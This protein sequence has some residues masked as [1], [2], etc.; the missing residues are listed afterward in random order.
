MTITTPRLRTS[1]AVAATM[2]P[3]AASM[4]LNFDDQDSPYDAIDVLTLAAFIDGRQPHARTQRLDN[5]RD[6]ATLL[7][8][9]ATA[10]RTARDS[11]G[12]KTLVRGDGWTLRAARW[13]GG[14]G[15]VTVTAV[16]DHL[17]A[18]ILAQAVDNAE[19]PDPEP[20][21]DRVD[22]GFW[23][24]TARGPYRR[25]RSIT[26]PM[27]SQLRR[28]YSMSVGRAM[29]ALVGL[30]ADHLAGQILLL[31]GPP[32]TGKT[33]ALRALAR[34][35]REWCQVDFVVDPESLF[36]EPGYLTEVI[37]GED[38]ESKW[39]LLLLEDCDELIRSDAKQA[40]GQ[41]L[42]RLLNLT[43]GLLGQGRRVLVAITTNE[44]LARLHPAITRPG[45]CLAQIEVSRLS[46]AEAVA[47]LG[48]S[49]SVP[50]A[51]ATLAELYALRD[52][53]GPVVAVPTH[54]VPGLY[55]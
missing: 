55:L 26:A 27:W 20:A 31:H 34:E 48:T 42:A 19:L 50:V 46:H 7:P 1:S 53:T 43:D 13:R 28:N 47:W 51:G 11:T 12:E 40:T 35:W 18:S 54:P 24:R 29:D 9:G 38:D 41:S 33:T 17:A 30:D 25:V 16:T 6:D 36:A 45:R 37:I 15:E 10:V 39:R 32:G 44:N 52:G 3:A 23:Y 5:V 22:L 8:P 21:D 4:V 14:G 49:T 2:P